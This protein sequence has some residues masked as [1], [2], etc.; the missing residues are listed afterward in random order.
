[1]P[2][3]S[4]FNDLDTV[5]SNNSPPGAESAKGNVDNYLRAAFAF[6]KTLYN[7]VTTA[8]ATADAALPKTGGQLGT[9][10]MTGDMIM[11]AGVK[12]VFEGATDDAH[13]I[14]LD[15]GNPTTDRTVTFPDKSGTFAMLSDINAATEAAAG[16][17]ELATQAE[18]NAGADDARFITPLKLATWGGVKL[19][20][21]SQTWQAVTRSS[22]TTYYNTTGR[23]IILSAYV[24]GSSS[25][26]NA[27]IT[28]NGEK[29]A[30][31]TFS[32]A[33]GLGGATIEAVIP[34]DASYVVTITSGTWATKELR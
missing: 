5:A 21:L 11:A 6:I 10:T 12:I 31:Q 32:V 33:G 8:Q 7:S 25:A 2:V 1:M 18:T 4:S 13:E 16:I 26:N 34:T 3:P 27:S 24:S 9:T 14:A 20:G 30:E 22:G 23:P 29:V 19:L 15:P 28:V 17:A